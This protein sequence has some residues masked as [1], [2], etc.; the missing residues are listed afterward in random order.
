MGAE[1]V[2]VAGGRARGVVRRRHAR[3]A[4]HQVHRSRG[5]RARRPHLGGPGRR[6]RRLPG[7]LAD[8]RAVEGGGRCRRQPPADRQA[9]RRAVEV[10]RPAR[11][12]GAR[13]SRRRR[14]GARRRGTR[15]RGLPRRRR[16]HLVH[17]GHHRPEQGSPQRAP[18]DRPGGSGLGRARRADGGRPLPGREPVLPLLRL[19]GRHRGV[20]AQRRDRCPPGGVRRRRDA[21][22]DRG[23][24]DHRAPRSACDLPLAARGTGTRRRRPVLPAARGHGCGRRTRRARGAHADRAR[25]STP[26]SPLSG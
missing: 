25:P 23:G 14:A 24:A 3:A 1:L 6:R 12:R 17:V 16:R 20:A 11:L 5:R 19:Q 13:S 18:A 10:R 15:R 7:P 2:A 9:R 26:C 21:A 4:Q 22:A 8:R